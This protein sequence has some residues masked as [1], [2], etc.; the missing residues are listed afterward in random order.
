MPI[1]D[2]REQLER[3]DSIPL[4]CVRC[5]FQTVIP[6]PS[7]GVLDALY[8]VSL[9]REF[10][11]ELMMLQRTKALFDSFPNSRHP[12]KMCKEFGSKEERPKMEADP[13]LDKALDADPELK[14][15]LRRSS[16]WLPARMKF[17]TEAIARCK[18]PNLHLITCTTCEN[19]HFFIEPN[20]FENVFQGVNANTL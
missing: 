3:F 1:V 13:E 12:Q 19:G 10:Q 16:F 2:K 6:K 4:L 9:L 17:V 14:A 7:E 15:F 18:K 8:E 5:S 11:H 20:F